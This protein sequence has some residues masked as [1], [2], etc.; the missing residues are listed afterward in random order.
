MA[1]FFARIGRKGQGVSPPISGDE[2]VIFASDKG[3]VKHPVTGQSL[4]PR[5]LLGKPA[6]IPDD[7]DPRRV[8]ADWMTSPENP[9]FAKVAVNRVWADVMGRGLVEPIDDLRA[10]NPPTNAPLLDALADR[11]RRDGYD[12][13]KLLRTILLSQVYALASEP[14]ADNVGDLR[15]YS[16]HYRQRL[17]A[18]VLL[19][20]VDDVTGVREKFAAAPIGTRAMALWTVRTE[21]LFLDA[22]GR[23]DPNQDPP[24]ERSTE[25]SVV[26]ALHLMN[27]PALQ[28]KITSDEGRA[29]QLAGSKKS[30][31][32][33]VTELYLAIYSR[34]PDAREQSICRK[35]FESGTTRQ[36]TEDV[37][38]SLINTPE[39]V[40]KD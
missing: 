27:A 10:T 34:R 7:A 5:T 35:L 22:F 26:Q 39:F 1:A 23:P 25:T 17:R 36:A 2:E 21:A 28:R 18:E 3:D 6:A 31:D 20:A 33:I 19:D 30:P 40:M 11:F 15:N 29:A 37:M 9:Y 24:C 38:W 14:N 8:L 32:E 4:P 13:K 16:R 12:F